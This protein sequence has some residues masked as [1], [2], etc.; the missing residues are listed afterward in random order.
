MEF[1]DETKKQ[2]LNGFI[3]IFTRIASKEYQKRIWI[4]GEGPEVD[5]FD[6]TVCDFFVECDS[7]LENYKYFGITN[8]Q[9]LLL[10]KFRTAFDE[11]V[12]G[13][14]P[15]LTQEFID[16]SEWDKITEMAQETL[17]AFNYQN[18]TTFSKNEYQ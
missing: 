9:Y 15:Y 14:K 4:R 16:T 17:I 8:P 12:N 13:P 5:D 2:I 18:Y 6:D 11:F 7:I 10:A 3:D 1:S